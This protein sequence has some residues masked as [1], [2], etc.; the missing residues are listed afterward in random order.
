MQRNKSRDGE[1]VGCDLCHHIFSRSVMNR[2]HKTNLNFCEACYTKLFWPNEKKRE[3]MAYIKENF[4]P[5]VRGTPD[6]IDE[7]R[8]VAG[9]LSVD[10]TSIRQRSIDE[11]VLRSR[12]MRNKKMEKE[13]Y[14]NTLKRLQLEAETAGIKQMPLLSDDS[15][16]AGRYSAMAQYIIAESDIDPN[17]V[18]ILLD[19]AFMPLSRTGSHQRDVEIGRRRK[20]RSEIEKL[21]SDTRL[22][23][24][25]IYQ[26]SRI[27][28]PPPKPI[29]EYTRPEIKSESYVPGQLDHI[30]Q[31]MVN[32]GYKVETGMPSKKRKYKPPSGSVIPSQYGKTE[33]KK[34]EPEKKLTSFE[35]S[36]KDSGYKIENV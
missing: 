7:L 27:I 1:N 28:P 12:A 17:V 5:G 2:I 25:G 9:V 21:W 20:A 24:Q 30:Q 23:N 19:E 8:E 16:V 13:N 29:P 26:E 35:Q 15:D 11:G 33:E 4:E 32:A 34:K 36:L 22:N 31:A 3:V 18:G 6:V 14:E 10:D